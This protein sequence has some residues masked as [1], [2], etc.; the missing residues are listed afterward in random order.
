MQQKRQVAM[1]DEEIIRM[2]R[3]ADREWDCDRNMYEWLEHFARLVAAQERE[4]CAKTC[5]SIASNPSSLWSESGCWAH[6]AEACA[7]EIR[8][9]S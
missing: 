1:T 6:A 9:R 5:E 4:A 8:E 2:A 3:E 7:A